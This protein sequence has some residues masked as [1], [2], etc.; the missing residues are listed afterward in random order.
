MECAEYD[1]NFNL[2]IPY[3]K[4]ANAQTAY[5]VDAVCEEIKKREKKFR[6]YG[7]K[8]ND[9]EGISAAEACA[10]DIEIVRNGRTKE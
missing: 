5:D 3:N 4:V 6:E 1:A 7:E 9:G 8:Y 10:G 2:V